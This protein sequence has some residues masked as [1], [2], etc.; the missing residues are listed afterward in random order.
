MSGKNFL[1]AL[2]SS[3]DYAQAINAF[4]PVISAC[5]KLS[6]GRATEKDVLKS[7]KKYL[8]R[9]GKDAADSVDELADIFENISRL[10]P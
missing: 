1:D 4:T 5:R 3:D 10:P 2:L 9:A 8:R 7:V 6:E